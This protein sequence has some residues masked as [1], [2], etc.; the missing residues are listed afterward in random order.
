M[1][2]E[3]TPSLRA[4]APLAAQLALLLIG[5]AAAVFTP[6]ARGTMLLVPLTAQARGDVAALAIAGDARLIGEGPIG[7]TLL[8]RGDRGR[9]GL[10]LLRHG[11]VTVAAGE[12]LC[13]TPAAGRGRA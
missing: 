12:I 3:S 4:G 9:L 11:I 10:A 5:L 7:G 13:G 1:F 8:I 2:P 6:P